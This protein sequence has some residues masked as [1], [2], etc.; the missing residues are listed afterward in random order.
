MLKKFNFLIFVLVIIALTLTGCNNNQAGEVITGEV[1]EI[2]PDDVIIEIEDVEEPAMPEGDGYPENMIRIKKTE[3]DLISLKPDAFDPDG[4][5]VYYAFSE[6]FDDDGEWQTAEGD[7]GEYPVTI[8]ASDGRLSTSETVLVIVGAMNKPPVVECPET[9]TLMETELLS[10]D[11]NIYDPEGKNITIDYAGWINTRQYQTTT[12]DEGEHTVFVTS[13]DGEQITTKTITIIIEN[14]N[15]PPE[16]EDIEDII[17]EENQE[18][19]VVVDAYDPEG[20]IITFEYGEP[21]DE[22]GSWTTEIGDSGE[23]DSFVI[24][25]DG[26][27]SV[28]K[29]FKIIVEQMNTAPTLDYIEPIQVEEGEVI[30]LPISAYDREGNALTVVIEGWFDTFSYNTTYED[31]GNHTVT[32]TIDDGKLTT[33]QDVEIEVLDVNRAPIF[34]I[35]V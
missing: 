10:I 22:T 11:C 19:I 32:V 4:D 23:Y 12:E 20:E 15:L 26:K 34:K 5:L 6:P 31:S 28:T 33:S 29:E 2:G 17:V 27:N 18:A 16:V 9:I 7:R 13:E 21:L 14:L 3:G 8:T 25:S 30:I 24:V 1:I 35:L